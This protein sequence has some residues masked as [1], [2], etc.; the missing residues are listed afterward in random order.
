M[1]TTAR[2]IIARAL[3]K[4]GVLSEGET[5]TASQAADALDDLNDL[6]ASW[7]TSPLLIPAVTQEDFSVSS[8]TEY[9][10][11]AMRFLNSTVRD[12]STD[13]PVAALSREDW[14]AIPDK[15]STGRPEA[16][17][18]DSGDPAAV[19]LWPVPDK[20]Y[21]MSLQREDALQE[22][23]T[24]DDE[25]AL[26]N[27]YRRAFVYNLAVELAPDY[28]RTV[29]VEV[30]ARAQ[31]ALERIQKYNAEEPPLMSVDLVGTIERRYSYG[32]GGWDF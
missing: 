12:G 24:L 21:Q 6:L 4:I 27:E 20:T 19:W 10:N 16:F 5:P 13:Y 7:S 32:R 3:T 30:A 8:A 23:P 22:F 2:K 15:L 11:P 14:L 31:E 25:F 1:A 18:V 9:T 26:P 28:G 17:W 29:P